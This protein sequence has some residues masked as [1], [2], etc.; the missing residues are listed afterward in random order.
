MLGVGRVVLF[1]NAQVSWVV[2]LQISFR[3]PTQ[4]AEIGTFKTVRKV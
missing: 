4:P 2:E 3:Y 1:Q